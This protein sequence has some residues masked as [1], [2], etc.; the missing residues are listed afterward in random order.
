MGGG[1]LRR[2][3]VSIYK[4]VLA[5]LETWVLLVSNARTGKKASGRDRRRS[6]KKQC[7]PQ[8]QGPANQASRGL[9]LAPSANEQESAVSKRAG[10]AGRIGSQKEVESRKKGLHWWVLCISPS[11]GDVRHFSYLH[12]NPGHRGGHIYRRLLALRNI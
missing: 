6:G 8:R 5:F 11:P 12:T 7:L 10:R 4:L 9:T 2:P 3:S 1:S